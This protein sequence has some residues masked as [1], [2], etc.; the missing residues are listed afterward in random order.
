MKRKISDCVFSRFFQCELASSKFM[1]VAGDVFENN[2]EILEEI[3]NL[4]IHMYLIHIENDV[5]M[6]AKIKILVIHISK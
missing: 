4:V 6:L 1:I 3:K 5:E 2:V